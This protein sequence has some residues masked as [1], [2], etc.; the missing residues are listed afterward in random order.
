MNIPLVLAMNPILAM[1]GQIAAFVIC[2]FLL[3]A[4]ILAVVLNVGL[5]FGLS[6]LRDQVEAIKKI[7][8]YV[9]TINKETTE[10]V[11]NNA[12]PAESA[13]P[14]A[15]AVASV[16][17]RINTIDQKVEQTSDR[18]ANAAIEFRARTE[19]VKMVARAF[20]LPG[21]LK[22]RTKSITAPVPQEGERQEAASAAHV[23]PQVQP[24][25][26]VQV[27]RGAR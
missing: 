2:L 13:N 5:A 7:R 21:S 26:Q 16:P 18:V 23:A 12:L 10:A 17:V 25:E 3:I 9:D 20:F 15:R 8:P 4:V 6:A 19:Q 1:A 14:V 24:P 11:R 27:M 22:R